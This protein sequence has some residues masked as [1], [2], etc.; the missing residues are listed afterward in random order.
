MI[1]LNGLTAHSGEAYFVWSSLLVGQ[2]FLSILFRS[3]RQ[4][5][6]KLEQV[7]YTHVILVK[8]IYTHILLVQIIYNHVILVQVIYAHII[9]LLVIMTMLNWSICSVSMLFLFRAPQKLVH[10]VVDPKQPWHCLL[11]FDWH[12]PD[13]DKKVAT[14]IIIL[15]KFINLWQYSIK[16]IY[17]A[18]I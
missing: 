14:F 9:L 11:N 6:T 12:Q 4:V 8:V 5:Y 10:G 3:I 15:Q 18:Y 17:I 2:V 7:I 1:S 13:E 16:L